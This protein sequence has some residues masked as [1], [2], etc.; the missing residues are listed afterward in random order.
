MYTKCS[1]RHTICKGLLVHLHPANYVK[2]FPGTSLQRFVWYASWLQVNGWTSAKVLPPTDANKMPPNSTQHLQR[3]SCLLAPSRRFT[4]MQTKPPDRHS[5]CR[6]PNYLHPAT[7]SHR[8]T[9]NPL[10]GTAFAEEQLLAC[11]LSHRRTQNP[12]T[13]IAFAE[14]QLFICLHPPSASRKCARN[15]LTGIAFPEVHL[16]TCNQPAFRVD[17]NEI[18]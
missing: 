7:V 13:R 18:S 9:R 2:R 4:H 3:S 5:I 15:P 17:A 14:V 12:L 1:D 10:T 11:S 6:G 16:F 8:R